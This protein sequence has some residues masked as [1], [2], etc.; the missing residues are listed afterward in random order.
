MKQRHRTPEQVLRKLAEDEKL[1]AQG[2]SI[3]GVARHLE[4]TQS[5]LTEDAPLDQ[6]DPARA[7]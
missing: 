3:E 1:L 7:P 2:Q 4:I 5:E 6:V